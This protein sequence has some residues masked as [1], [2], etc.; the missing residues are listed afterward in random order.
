VT[1]Y[2]LR[3]VLQAAA[4][5]LL[6][7][8]GV[9]GMLWLLPGGPQQALLSGAAAGPGITQATLRRDYGLG[10]PVVIAYLHWLGQVSHGNLGY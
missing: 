6:L 2:L 1:T 8:M 7:S 9:F 4:A 3:R 5:L 10:S